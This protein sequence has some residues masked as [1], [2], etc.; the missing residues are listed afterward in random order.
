MSKRVALYNKILKF[1]YSN[2]LNSDLHNV[3]KTVTKYYDGRIVLEVGQKQQTPFK[4]MAHQQMCT[5]KHLI[6]PIV[7]GRYY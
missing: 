2:E 4:K 3:S 7:T 1:T 5:W 6:E